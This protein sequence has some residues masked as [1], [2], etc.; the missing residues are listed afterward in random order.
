MFKYNSTTGKYI[1]ISVKL[2]RNCRSFRNA[3]LVA[4]SSCVCYLIVVLMFMY[5]KL[6]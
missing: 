5:M 4:Y 1:Y 2:L 3:R 6:N